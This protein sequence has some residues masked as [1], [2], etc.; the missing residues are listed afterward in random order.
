VDGAK[1]KRAKFK[2]LEVKQNLDSINSF[3]DPN[4]QYV[5]NKYC[6]QMGEVRQDVTKEQ[7]KRGTYTKYVNFLNTVSIILSMYAT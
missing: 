3:V 2:F 5:Y 6:L 4:P 1:K 7:H